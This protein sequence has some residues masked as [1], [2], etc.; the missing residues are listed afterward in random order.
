MKKNKNIIRWLEE[1]A[2]ERRIRIQRVPEE[3]KRERALEQQRERRSK[4]KENRR[5]EGRAV[6]GTRVIRSERGFGVWSINLG[7]ASCD[8]IKVAKKEAEDSGATVA[9]FQ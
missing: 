5:Q 1:H 3:G 6:E 8:K 7:G 9:I 2:I 4:Q